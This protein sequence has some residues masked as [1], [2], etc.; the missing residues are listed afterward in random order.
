M[1]PLNRISAKRQDLFNCADSL[2]SA[3]YKIALT[4]FLEAQGV[5]FFLPVQLNSKI[6]AWRSNGRQ[7]PLRHSTVKRLIK[8]KDPT[9]K[10]HRYDIAIRT[11]KWHIPNRSAD[12]ILAV[13]DFD[14]W[15]SVSDD[16][17]NLVLQKPTFSI[18]TER[19]RHFYFWVPRYFSRSGSRRDIGDWLAR[20]RIAVVT[21]KDREVISPFP[22]QTLDYFAARRL[23]RYMTEEP[24][25]EWFP[26]EVIKQHYRDFTAPPLEGE[27]NTRINGELYRLR[28]ILS[29]T[30]VRDKAQEMA[31][32]CIPPYPPKEAK[33]VAESIIRNRHRFP[34]Q[35]K[36]QAAPQV[37]TIPYNNDIAY[38]R[39]G[40]YFPK[41]GMEFTRAEY[42]QHLEQS[43]GRERNAQGRIELA[44]KDIDHNTKLGA[45]EIVGTRSSGRGRPVKVYRRVAD[46]DGKTDYLMP[47][48]ITGRTMR[49]SLMLH[50]LPDKKMAVVR[51]K[52][53]A[54]LGVRVE[55]ISR[56]G[57]FLKQLGFITL[58]RQKPDYE[59]VGPPDIAMGRAV[60]NDIA[61]GVW[62]NPSI[63]Q[64]TTLYHRY[65]RRK[66]PVQW[67]ITPIPEDI[68]Q[69]V[70]DTMEQLLKALNGKAPPK[71]LPPS[72]YHRHPSK[73]G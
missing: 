35:G 47:G 20:G 13:L 15:D 24:P 3:D 29:D 48:K 2:R 16:I 53:A 58:K 36:G 59:V 22:I 55:T 63:Y 19:G 31:I 38:T 52:L 43:E 23:Y 71:R 67:D 6:P 39:L 12:T 9:T 73:H 61:I 56:Y 28:N 49:L 57:K 54:I 40:K 25:A 8:A 69:A 37:E 45:I 41:K 17:K 66:Q 42:E 30:E 7:V 11:G 50:I 18:Q 4:H 5:T 44:R 64:R 60:S 10:H 46:Y 26:G 34:I 51:S 32:A 72:P 70:T 68:P 1:A 14:Y 21:G 33:A 62:F 65:R 27:R